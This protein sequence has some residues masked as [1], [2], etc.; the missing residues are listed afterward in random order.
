L[1]AAPNEREGV[2]YPIPAAVAEGLRTAS[3]GAF[4]EGVSGE[5][6]TFDSLIDLARA[7][8][9]VRAGRALEVRDSRVLTWGDRSDETRPATDVI[10]TPKGGGEPTILTVVLHSERRGELYQAL[11]ATAPRKAR[12]A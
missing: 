11:V 4:V 5:L 7:I 9:A 2:L 12:A 8:H 10:L 6:R 3:Y 1:T